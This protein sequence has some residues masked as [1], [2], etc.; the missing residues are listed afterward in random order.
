MEHTNHFESIMVIGGGAWGTALACVT[1][2]NGVETTL[3]ARDDEVVSAINQQGENIRYLPGIAVP[4]GL[5]ATSDLARTQDAD[6]LLF[7]VPAQSARDMF[8]AMV[9]KDRRAL[10]IAIASKGIE[11]ETLQL[12]PAVLKDVWPEARPAM[13]SGPSFAHDVARGLPTAVTLACVHDSDG[14]RWTKT[15]GTRTFRPYLSTDID[16]VALGGAVKNVLAIAAGIVDGLGIGESARAALIARGFAEFQRLGRA[17]GVEANTMVGLSGL[18][19]LILT[20]NSSKSR[21]M[22]LGQALGRGESLEDILASRNSVSEGVMTADALIGLA[23]R[24]GIELPISQSIGDLIDGRKSLDLI[25]KELLGRPFRSE[26][27]MD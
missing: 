9:G 1:A 7:V 15:L 22:S 2:S 24:Y 21:N 5:Q 6:A 19:D 10:P 14:A 27:D 11:R 12:M 3:W 17:M 20:A 13:L 25:V 26:T 8:K 18:G 16:G 23:Q 4:Q